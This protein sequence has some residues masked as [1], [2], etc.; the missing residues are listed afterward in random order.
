VGRPRR[1]LEVPNRMSTCC[2][3]A[4]GQR[5]RPGIRLRRQRV[6]RRRRL[7][8]KGG[9]SGQTLPTWPC[10]GRWRGR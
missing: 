2:H 5:N 6:R 1:G 8:A 9:N 3:H 4:A 10:A 7:A